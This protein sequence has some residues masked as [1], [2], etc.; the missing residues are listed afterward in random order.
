M[1]E[2]SNRFCPLR[3]VMLY[4][5]TDKNPCGFFNLIS[6]VLLFLMFV[7]INFQEGAMGADQL[8]QRI[9]A[10]LQVKQ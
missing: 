2:A 6:G 7:R 5:A 8:I 4:F 1:S 10:S 3:L 9:E